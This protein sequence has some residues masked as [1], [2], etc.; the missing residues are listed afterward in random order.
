MSAPGLTCLLYATGSD[1]SN[2]VGGAYA[3]VR[4][5]L[6]GVSEHVCLLLGFKFRGLV[7]YMVYSFISSTF[8]LPLR[9]LLTLGQE[10][11]SGGFSKGILSVSLSV[12]V[13]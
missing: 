8:Y 6:L 10:L 13:C 2:R 11:M 4:S 7:L 3:L 5:S 1:G 9:V 12:F